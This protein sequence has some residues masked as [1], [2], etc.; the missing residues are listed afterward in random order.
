MCVSCAT[1]ILIYSV[2]I[3]LAFTIPRVPGF[4]FN[5]QTPLGNST[6]ENA[7]A[8]VFGTFPA[9]FTFYSSIDVEINTNSNFLPLHFNSWRSE[10]YELN[11]GKKIA[12]GDWG[13]YTLPAKKYTRIILPVTFNYTA[14]NTT[15][16]TW[17]NIY[18]SCRNKNQSVDNTRPGMFFYPDCVAKASHLTEFPLLGMDLTVILYMSIAGLINQAAAS[19]TLTS[20]PC[21]FELA[22]NAS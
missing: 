3:V 15:D 18:N 7:P 6:L 8:P 2:G 20:V 21:P 10:I 4:A 16:L 13:S 11:T 12:T 5:T 14:A 22:T 1:L 17:A 9:N 19:Q